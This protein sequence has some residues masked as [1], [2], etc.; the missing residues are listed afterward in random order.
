VGSENFVH[1]MCDHMVLFG[2]RLLADKYWR[3]GRDDACLAR[4]SENSLV[5]SD[6]ASSNDVFKHKAIRIDRWP[7]VVD[8]ANMLTRYNNTL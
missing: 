5:R 2:L 4:R 8:V 6:L 3:C 7:G 1:L